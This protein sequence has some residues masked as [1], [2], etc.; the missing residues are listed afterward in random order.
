MPLTA[1]VPTDP[2]RYT[3]RRNSTP[4]SRELAPGAYVFVQDCAGT[5][6]VLPDG[7]H[8]HPY[9]LGRA[10]PA[11]AAGEL[12][13]E[14]NGVVTSINNLSGTFLC[15]PDCLFTAVGGLIAQGATI[16]A[17]AIHRFPLEE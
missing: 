15:H 16:T 14:E 17:D 4:F 3:Q 10:R 5:V 6:W 12:M 11:V 2:E 9:V 8:V 1:Y 13:V 7:C